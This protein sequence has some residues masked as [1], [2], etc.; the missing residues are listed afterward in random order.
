MLLLPTPRPEWWM[1]KERFD[2][3]TE[4]PFPGDVIGPKGPACVAVYGDGRTQ[5]GWGLAYPNSSPK[6]GQPNFMPRYNRGEFAA[7]VAVANYR[8]KQ[9]PFAF[10]MR[11]LQMICVDIDGKN[12][13]FDSTLRLGDLPVTLA[14]TSKSGNGV[15]LFYRTDEPWD[16]NTGYGLFSD[17]IGLV[18]GIDLRATGCVF[19]YPTQLWNNEELAPI[20]DQLRELLTAK[21]ERRRS[22]NRTK[23]LGLVQTTQ[24]DP[25]MT[26][27]AQMLTNAEFE[28]ELKRPL[29]SGGRNN[30]LFALGA[31]ARQANIEDWQTKIADKAIEVGLDTAEIEKLIRNIENYA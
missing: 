28:E 29:M 1:E 15:H 12:G 18:Q 27:L 5:P 13:G 9:S 14:E 4:V 22:I 3:D 19:H 8:K 20:P 16:E 23:A 17:H 10:V 2:R 7:R 31:K 30:A 25:E 26:E 21:A 24:E 6:A 11:S